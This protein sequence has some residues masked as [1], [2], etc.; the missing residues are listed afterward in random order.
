MDATTKTIDPITESEDILSDGWFKE[1]K[2]QQ[3]YR[4]YADAHGKEDT[5]WQGF[6]ERANELGLLDENDG[7]KSLPA[8]EKADF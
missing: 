1:Q 7:I 2:I 3:F 6:Q 5:D 4:D 8:S